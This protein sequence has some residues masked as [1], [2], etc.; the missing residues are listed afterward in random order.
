MD[1]V[2]VAEQGDHTMDIPQS[3]TS[4]MP[5]CPFIGE[6]YLGNNALTDA[7]T[8]LREKQRQNPNWSTM[9]I[10]AFDLPGLEPV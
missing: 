1:G 3:L 5:P 6:L 7:T 4:W 10:V 8:L 2:T 9:R